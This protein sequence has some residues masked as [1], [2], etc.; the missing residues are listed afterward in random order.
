MV[1]LGALLGKWW[2]AKQRRV[3]D[4]WLG[5][6]ALTGVVVVAELEQSSIPRRVFGSKG[7]LWG[8]VRLVFKLGL[9]GWGQQ[10]FEI[11]KSVYPRALNR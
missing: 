4:W 10:L 1:S 7:I 5:G 8:V 9:T 2:I 6:F 11:V 3:Q